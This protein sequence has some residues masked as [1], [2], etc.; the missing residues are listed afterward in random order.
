MSR[1]PLLQPAQAPSVLRNTN[2]RV[3]LNHLFLKGPATR[4]ALAKQAG[5]S[6]PTV[7]A[8]FDDLERAG[9]VRVIDAP[10]A[11][12]GRPAAYYEANPSAGAVICIDVG[13]AWVQVMICDLAGTELARVRGRNTART[14]RGLLSQ[15]DRLTQRAVMTSGLELRD[16]TH[17]VL[18][19]PGVFDATEQRFTYAANLPGWDAPGLVKSLAE[20]IGMP[21]A[22]ENDVN[23][24]AL[25]EF[26]CGAGQG[27]DPLA[28]IHVGTGV[29]LGVI[30]HGEIFRGH[31]GAAGEIAYL[32]IGHLDPSGR[33]GRG[34]LEESAAAD[35][36][37]SEAS[38]RG[39]SG[40]FDAIEVFAAARRGDRTALEVLHVEARYIAYAVASVTAMFD[41]QRVILGGGIGQNLD[42]LRDGIQGTLKEIT[43]LPAQ[44]EAGTL[45]PNAVL[46]GAAAIG[47]ETAQEIVFTKRVGEISKA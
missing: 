22:T 33:V 11:R 7:N 12:T 6:L 30:M 18:G 43:P 32:P 8:V 38:A 17:A 37:V 14:D 23:L 10:G 13:R 36:L 2:R 46:K 1:Y 44:V 45:G 19:S 26:A 41:P 3:L 24:A 9:L 21:V 5:L 29:G 15:I 28:Y 47:I 39:L 42:M 35:A 25:G 31:T 27:C 16:V 34:L 4:P 40:G 20:R